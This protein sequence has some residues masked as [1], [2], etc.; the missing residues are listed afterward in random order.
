MRHHFVGAA[1]ALA[2]LILI[3][4]ALA[5][6]ETAGET[7]V[8]KDGSSSKAGRGA[9]R[10]HGGVDKAA[11]AKAT[12]GAAT[13]AAEAKGKKATE[14]PGQGQSSAAGK[15]DAK[16]AETTVV[17]KDG[18]T[19]KGGRGACRGHGGVDKNAAMKGAGAAA[20]PSAAPTPPPPPAAAPRA[21]APPAQ[22][23][24]PAGKSAAASTAR[25]PPN[26]KNTDPTGAIAKCKDG[27]YSHAKG[28]TGAC[29]RHGGVAEWLDK[30]ENR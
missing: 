10:G 5:R 29:S 14:S 15:A 27:T 21:P 30:T 22:G 26:A 4:P 28:H 6:A 16:A 11:S 2:A 20:S 9:C 18:S 13:T 8:C 25:A 24:A 7:V 19:S 17:C 12:G 1:T 3:A 23:A